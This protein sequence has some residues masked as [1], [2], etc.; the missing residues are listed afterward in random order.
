MIKMEGNHLNMDYDRFNKFANECNYDLSEPNPQ[1]PQFSSYGAAPQWQGT[2]PINPGAPIQGMPLVSSTIPGDVASYLVNTLQ[3]MERMNQQLQSQ[4]GKAK[5]EKALTVYRIIS[6]DQVLKLQRGYELYPLCKDF[7]TFAVWVTVEN[8]EKNSRFLALGFSDRKIVFLKLRELNSDGLLKRLRI[9]TR[10]RME[11]NGIPDTK[12]SK[13]MR[14]YLI[15]KAEDNNEIVIPQ[16]AGWDLKKKQFVS[17]RQD[18][19]FRTVLKSQFPNHPLVRRE[20]QNTANAFLKEEVR[21]SKGLHAFSL[22]SNRETLWEVFVYAAV[23]RS[24]LVHA[25]VRDFFGIW[26]YDNAQT[27]AFKKSRLTVWKDYIPEGDAGSTNELKRLFADSKDEIIIIRDRTH[28]KK[29]QENMGRIVD[30]LSTNSE[31]SANIPIVSLPVFISDDYTI[32]QGRNL[33]VFPLLFN[34]DETFYMNEKFRFKICSFIEWCEHNFSLVQ[35]LLNIVSQLYEIE[36]EHKEIPFLRTFI[37]IETLLSAYYC[38]NQRVESVLPEPD[39]LFRLLNLKETEKVCAECIQDAINFNQLSSLEIVRKCLIDAYNNN[40][41]RVQSIDQVHE[42]TDLQ[43]SLIYDRQF[44]VYIAVQTFET[45]LSQNWY[46][47][48]AKNLIQRLVE[49]DILET[50]RNGDGRRRA[51]IKASIPRGCGRNQNRFYKFKAGILLNESGC[52]IGTEPKLD[53]NACIKLGQDEYGYGIFYPYKNAQ[54]LHITV[55]GISGSGKT[56]TTYELVYQLCRKG[57]PCLL[58]DYSYSYNEDVVNDELTDIIDLED[59]P[60]NPFLCRVKEDSVETTDECAWRGMGILSKVLHLKDNDSMILLSALDEL[61]KVDISPNFDLLFAKIQEAEL[62]QGS[63]LR[64]L[65][66]FCNKGIFCHDI[67]NWDEFFSGDAKLKIVRMDALSAGDAAL[68][69]D[70]LLLD[71]IDWRIKFGNTRNPVMLWLDEIQN[72]SHAEEMVSKL[73]R[74]MRKFGLGIIAVSQAIYS[75]SNEMQVALQQSALKL[76]FRQDGR[77]ARQFANQEADTESEKRR[78]SRDLKTLPRGD[79]YAIGDFMD[80]NGDVLNAQRRKVYHRN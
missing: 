70:I 11:V 77:G 66:G 72:L 80:V 8:V 39:Q 30:C 59:F 50:E 33:T 45:L 54:N 32:F 36:S 21:K 23:S 56:F 74:E 38:S 63:K 7:L 79:F 57:I 48:S 55:T 78:L 26:L 49:D 34:A 6:E 22:K 68:L 67:Q 14:H 1:Q 28:S 47:Y 62:D 27:H 76:Y 65:R 75:F 46:P 31:F 24:L 17:L 19:L 69:T 2:P 9:E 37:M 40:Q 18:E 61:L 15:E 5:Q 12:I 20:L 35:K 41:I 10:L 52:L 16:K 73:F 42:Q 71:F 3:N 25:G 60:V 51:D 44:C 64:R 58:L 53:T 29:A 43:Y 4:L 13:A